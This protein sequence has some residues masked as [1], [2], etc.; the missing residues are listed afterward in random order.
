MLNDLN[1]LIPINSADCNVTNRQ[2]RE[3][4]RN[5]KTL[6]GFPIAPTS[7]SAA[8]CGI[9]G[10]LSSR[11]PPL[12][13][14]NCGPIIFRRQEAV[15]FNFF[16]RSLFLWALVSFWGA[17]SSSSSLA[18]ELFSFKS[19]ASECQI[20]KYMCFSHKLL[21]QFDKSWN[22]ISKATRYD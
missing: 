20:H 9:F 4:D 22:S 14:G 12:G 1:T 15:S 6:P 19:S 7:S 10:G 16:W 17:H 21:E 2:E 13:E 11:S 5:L 18:E 3:T 8:L